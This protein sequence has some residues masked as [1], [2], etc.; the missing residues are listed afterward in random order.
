MM[1]TSSEAARA[2]LSKCFQKVLTGSRTAPSPSK[3]VKPVWPPEQ[4]EE[5]EREEDVQYSLADPIAGINPVPQQ[6]DQPQ[7]VVEPKRGR[8]SDAEPSWDVSRIGSRQTTN[9]GLNLLVNWHP[10]NPHPSSNRL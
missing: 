5:W 6:Q 3:P 1:P 4:P 9:L 2:T 8:S 10:R 7:R